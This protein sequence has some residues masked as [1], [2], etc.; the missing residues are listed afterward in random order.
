MVSIAKRHQNNGY[1]MLLVLLI[2]GYI[3]PKIEENSIANVQII[4]DT[5]TNTDTY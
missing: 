4:H 1:V 5:M 3:L 2:G